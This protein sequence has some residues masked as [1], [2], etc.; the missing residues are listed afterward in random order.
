VTTPSTID[1]AS[2]WA[3]ERYQVIAARLQPISEAICEA[4]QLRG[5]EEILDVA[6]A[7]GNAALA[8]ARR[9]CAVTAIDL[10]PGMLAV[11][12]RRAETERLPVTLHQADA[13]RL[14][15]QDSSFD[16]VLSAYGAMFAPDARTTAREL[17]R[18]CRPGGRIVLANWPPRGVIDQVFA[19]IQ[20]HR[21]GDADLT[22][23]VTTWGTPEGLA[24]LFP[25]SHV[26][27]STRHIYV[28]AASYAT[29]SDTFLHHFGPAS[30]PPDAESTRAAELRDTLR[31]AFLRH[32]EPDGKGARIRH[33]YLEA[34]ITPH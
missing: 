7:T 29:W 34:I 22:R 28:Y 33:D 31:Q 2:F 25:T 30:P 20:A 1:E 14:P 9:G 19:A 27:T 5:T 23:A 26:V 21:P 8:A 3:A 15:F 32:N 13:Q 17:T 12:Q 18:V 24:N 10:D 4:A 6:C 16:T 11:A